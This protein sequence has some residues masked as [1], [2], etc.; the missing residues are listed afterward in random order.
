MSRDVT[1]SFGYDYILRQVISSI[2]K[3]FLSRYYVCA[4]AYILLQLFL[5][6]NNCSCVFFFFSCKEIEKLIKKKRWL[7]SYIL[8]W[9]IYLLLVK[10]LVYSRGKLALA[11]TP[12]TDHPE[13]NDIDMCFL[14]FGFIFTTV[15]L[16]FYPVMNMTLTWWSGLRETKKTKKWL[17]KHIDMKPLII[18]HQTTSTIQF[19][20]QV[21]TA[22]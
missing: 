4:F 5:S 10:F 6:R 19:Q 2:A 21:Q 1:A 18:Y 9:S 22:K 3:T 11:P 16:W 14:S 15:I 7:I 8:S 17:I 12:K 20:N 13:M